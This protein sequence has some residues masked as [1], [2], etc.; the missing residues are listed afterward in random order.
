MSA[1]TA[2]LFAADGTTMLRRLDTARDLG[3]TD[4][5]LSSEAEFRIPLSDAADLTAGRFVKLRYADGFRAGILLGAEQVD[6]STDGRWLS[7][8]QSREMRPGLLWDGI[9]MPQSYPAYG[10]RRRV[11]EDRWWGFMD[12]SFDDSGWSAPGSATRL[13]DYVRYPSFPQGLTDVDPNACWVSLSDGALSINESTWFRGH[14]INIASAGI[15]RLHLCSDDTADWY[16]D[17][18]LILQVKGDGNTLS[19]A[20]TIDQYLAVGPHVLA[21]KVTNENG[22]AGELVNEIVYSITTLV[23]DGNGGLKAGTVVARS[24]ASTVLICTTTMGEPGVT[25]A[26]ALLDL[27][28]EAKVRATTHPNGVSKLTPT[29]T[30]TLDSAGVAFTDLGE[31]SLPILTT[32]YDEAF[33]QLA[34]DVVDVDINVSTLQLNV[35]VRR[36]SD[37]RTTVAMMPASN[38]TSL[39]TTKD[40]ARLTHMF[41]R[42]ADGVLVET[43]DAAAEAA[44]GRVE[45]G[46][47]VGAVRSLRTANN[48]NL[49]ALAA[50][51]VP[52]VEFDAQPI[53]GA[54]TTW[55]MGDTVAVTNHR[56][57]TLAAA[58]VLG[59]RV[60]GRDD[61]A[62]VTPELVEDRS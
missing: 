11:A 55:G 24:A 46:Q 43:V 12:P 8:R 30:G 40:L 26:K 60:D 34:E 17:D 54:Y 56:G 27:V 47:S 32:R 50:S 1:V 2:W 48:L 36:G 23:D 38:A 62:T 49:A 9:V 10:V 15:Y 39:S 6:V 53:G 5:G 45:G 61:E 20:T 22:V 19:Q 37:K 18:E 44:Y 42:T 16:L 59:I 3:F 7:F 35:W 29:F 33:L 21:V 51:S 52:T 31:F 25:R 28:N 4:A 57:G 13:V 14:N 41:A 58:R